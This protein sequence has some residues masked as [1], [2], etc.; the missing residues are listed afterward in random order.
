MNNN[1]AWGIYAPY[2]RD[3]VNMKKSFGF[4]YITQ[5][6]ILHRFDRFTIERGETKVGISKE[7]ADKWCE[8]R[9]NE[10]DSNR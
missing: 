3:F 10:S 6:R 4:K 5:K 7:L 2:I 9:S 1:Q 8:R